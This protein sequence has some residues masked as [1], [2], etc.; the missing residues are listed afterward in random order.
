M[1]IAI[2]ELHSAWELL[3]GKNLGRAQAG[4][5]NALIADWGREELGVMWELIGFAAVWVVT[6]AWAGWAVSVSKLT[7]F[8]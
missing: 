1:R 4:T 2:G 6:W 7:R 8:R 3:V 5:V